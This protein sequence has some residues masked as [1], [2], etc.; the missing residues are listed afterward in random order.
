MAKTVEKMTDEELARRRDALAK[1]RSEVREEQVAVQAEID[2]RA[3][4]AAMPGEA[5]RVVELRLGGGVRPEGAADAKG[6][7]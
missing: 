4:L 1:Q 6:G 5:R 7:N 3:A 2:L